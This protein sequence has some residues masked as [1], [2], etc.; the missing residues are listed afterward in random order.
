[1]FNLF[2]RPEAKE[3]LRAIKHESPMDHARILVLLQEIAQDRSILQKLAVDGVSD[4]SA[5]KVDVTAFGAMQ[6]L[7]YD[8]WRIKSYECGKTFPMPYRLIY[9]VDNIKMDYHIFAVMKRI[10]G[11]D[12][13]NDPILVSRIRDI[14][15]QLGLRFC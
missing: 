6:K 14:Y 10:N 8:M 9:A 12:Y 15:L 11:K 5:F 1:M 4:L 7:H 2:I 3:D 13:E